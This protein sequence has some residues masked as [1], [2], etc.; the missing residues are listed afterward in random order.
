MPNQQPHL[1]II[2]PSYNNANRLAASLGALSAYCHSLPF[3]W[4]LV[5]VDDCSSDPRA[6]QL[7]RDFA[8]GEPGVTLL[9][10]ESNRGKGF[11]V[12]RGCLAARGAYRVF[13]DVDLAYPP[14]EIGAIL[15]AL[16]EGA[17]VAIACR[18]H[19]D[20]TYIMN[21]GFLHYL[22]TRHVMSRIFNL[23]VRALLLRDV[24]DTQAGLK[25]FTGRAAETIFP[26]LTISGFGFDVECLFV[27][28][29]HHLRIVQAPITF[30]YDSEPS[31]LNFVRDG[32]IMIR[33]LVHIWIG[34][35]RG[36]YD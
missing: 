33:D 5:L 27:A 7:L 2:V 13:T 11:S 34:G 35:F 3:S 21:V 20:S 22:Y 31:T 1:S 25:G 10:N 4:E 15:R 9:V 17:D 18:V 12:R 30:R 26:R 32:A 14:S 16:E 23:M 19:P 28:Q 29:R 8:A 36:R 24:R 6:V